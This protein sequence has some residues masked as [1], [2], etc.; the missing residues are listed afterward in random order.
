MKTNET[1]RAFLGA[2][3]ASGALALAG[4]ASEKRETPHRQ[5]I[6]N[7]HDFGAAATGQTLGYESHSIRH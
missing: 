3:G 2:C 4:S 5:G 6:F 7:V 1:R